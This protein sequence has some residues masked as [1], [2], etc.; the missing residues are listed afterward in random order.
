MKKF[1]LIIL[2]A[3]TLSGC[4]GNDD[5]LPEYKDI[6]KYEEAARMQMK[7]DSENK[8]DSLSVNKPVKDEPVDNEPV[9]LAHND[10]VYYHS[11]IFTEGGGVV[12]S[13]PLKHEYSSD[14]ICT[15][16]GAV[17][18]E[19]EWIYG[20][21]EGSSYTT[22]HFKARPDYSEEVIEE[23]EFNEEGVCSCG[24]YAS[25][26]KHIYLVHFT[27]TKSNG[28]NYEVLIDRNGNMVSFNYKEEDGKRVYYVRYQNKVDEEYY[29]KLFKYQDYDVYKNYCLDT[30]SMDI[31]ME[32]A[33]VTAKDY[34]VEMRESLISED[35]DIVM[36]E[37]E[38]ISWYLEHPDVSLSVNNQN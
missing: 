20:H 33:I 4:S 15:E 38:E 17:M 18:S 14:G 2:L 36:N 16:C 8:P 23:H 25:D 19:D 13:G 12:T 11:M 1:G 9:Y 30:P 26:V 35:F 29:N 27:G 37:T 21:I 32:G 34:P 3:L 22:H 5:M 7:W 6:Y 28:F 10:G 24:Y 31:I